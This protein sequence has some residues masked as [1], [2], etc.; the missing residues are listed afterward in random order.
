MD[1]RMDDSECVER[2]L[3]EA[4]GME[5][6]LEEV[7]ARNKKMR[8]T[9]AGFLGGEKVADVS[10]SA[11]R[12]YCDLMAW[13]LHQQCKNGG[14]STVHAYDASGDTAVYTKVMVGP[15]QWEQVFYGSVLLIRRGDARLVVHMLL[16]PGERADMV[17]TA[18]A[19]EKRHAEQFARA[20]RKRIA[21]KKLYRGANLELSGKPKFLDLAAI[22]WA[23][24]SLPPAIKEAIIA[25]TTRFLERAPELE[26]YG[27]SPRRGLLLTGKPGTGKTL[28]CKALMNTSP[29]VT[30]IA[31]HTGALY[32][33]MYLDDLFMAAADLSPC[34]VFFEDIDLI[35]QGRM[36]SHYAMADALS[37]LLFAL[38]GVEDCRNVVTVATTNWLEILDEALKDRPS[39]FDRVIQMDM[40]DAEQRRGYLHYLA[41][42]LPLADDAIEFLVSKTAGLTPAQIQEVVHCAAIEADLSPNSNEFCSSA[43]TI[44]ALDA[45]LRNVRH[46]AEKVGF[47][48]VRAR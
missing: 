35:G 27:V 19:G 9:I 34:M 36:R 26:R 31:A 40:P 32:N 28:V 29:G 44:A 38:D 21:E 47:E 15:R 17:V 7:R 11:H 10:V 20:I 46:E 42:R 2:E 45:A 30:C 25:N 48:A 6:Y 12:L 24:I 4:P 22:T 37:R 41:T 3:S 33:P 14:W 39:R 5:D 43:F 13:S 1:M 16:D 18:A 8:K 23:D